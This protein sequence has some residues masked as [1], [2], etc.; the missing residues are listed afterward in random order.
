MIGVSLEFGVLMIR[1]LAGNK[2]LILH[3][4]KIEFSRLITT[5]TKGNKI[6]QRSKNK[7]RK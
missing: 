4:K 7:R 2:I 3:I 6:N 5:A 1:T